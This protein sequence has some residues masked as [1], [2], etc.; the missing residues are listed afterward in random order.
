MESSACWRVQRTGGFGMLEGAARW[1]MQSAGGQ[2]GHGDDQS[3]VE[4]Q[5]AD[6][7]VSMRD[8]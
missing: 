2:G 8:G 4:Q 5:I 6:A 1:K 7:A 3:G